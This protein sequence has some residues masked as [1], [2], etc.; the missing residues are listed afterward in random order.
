LGKRSEYRRPC[1]LP[2]GHGVVARWDNRNPEVLLVPATDGRWIPGSEKQTADTSDSFHDAPWDE[3]AAFGCA[4]GR[5]I[6]GTLATTSRVGS[7]PT[8]RPASSW[9]FARP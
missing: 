3:R 4:R 1:F 5:C 8:L 2:P 9:R 7:F 6:Q